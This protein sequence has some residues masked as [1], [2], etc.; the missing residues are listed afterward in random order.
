MAAAQVSGAAALILSTGDQTTTNLKNDI[1]TNAD[2]T[3]ALTGLIRTGG[4][5][6]IC[7]AIPSCAAPP[8]SPPVNTGLPGIS[9]VA[10]VGQTLTASSG[11]WS[12]GPTSF[13]FAWQRC[14]AGGG[15]CGAISG[16]SGS[17]YVVQSVDAGSTLRVAVTATNAA[18]ASSPASSAQSG[19]VSTPPTTLTFGTTS[20]GSLSDTFAANRKRVS[21][22]SLP[23]AGSVSKLSLYLTPTSTS[24]QEN[25]EGV[26]YADS[27]GA[28]AGLLGV[29]SQLV[30]SSSNAAGWYDLSFPTPVGLAAG[31][32]W[33]GVITGGTGGVAGFRYSNVS[34]SR[35]YNLNT[36]TSGPSNPFG[37]T[38]IDSEQTS[39]YATYTPAPPPSSPPVNTGLPGI[40]G[41]AQVGQTLTASS[42]SW[43]NGPTSF[44]FAWQRCDAGGG[45]CGAISGASGSSYVVQSVDAGSTLRVAVTAT[46]AAGASSPAS[47]AQSGVVSTPPTTLT[48][49]TTSV[50]SLSDTFA[51]NRKRVSA[52]SLPGAGS[53]SKLSLYLTPTSTS[54]QENVE[55]VIYA[56]SGGAPAGLLGVSSQLV[57]SSSNAAG[58]YDLSFPTPVGLAAGRYWIGVITGGTG[59]VA[60]FRYSNVSSS[61]DYNLNTYTSG[62]SNPFGVTTIDSE[63]T[64]LYATYAPGG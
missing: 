34:S 53:V 23:G 43:S 57:F 42:G 35:D 39:L 63:Q 48:F 44:A 41:V 3:P 18:G 56:D 64:S 49:G 1:L 31:R 47:S 11:S 61:R 5:L 54:G 27:G 45:S 21:A 19:V 38:T 58:W 4:R 22:Y 51:A 15:S 52:Y 14:D 32:Y 59:G 33:I 25:V 40:S 30:F 24:G 37:V 60:G 55:G 13:A 8:S 17:S 20:V 29:S 50:G 36:Y 46:N 6:N 12:N 2:P 10:Q 7:K 26:I 9:G 16:A 62:P 28:P